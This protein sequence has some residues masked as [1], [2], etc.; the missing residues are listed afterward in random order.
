MSIKLLGLLDFACGFAI[1]FNDSTPAGIIRILGLLLLGKGSIF[2]F[3]GDIA[4]YIDVVCAVY[5]FALSF[6]IYNVAASA[7]TALFLAQKAVLTFLS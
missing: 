1:V 2:A 4:S 7:I 3:G 5:M 6:G